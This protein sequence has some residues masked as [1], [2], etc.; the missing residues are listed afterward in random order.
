MISIAIWV[1]GYGVVGAIS[2]GVFSYVNRLSDDR[3]EIAIVTAAVFFLWPIAW[4]LGALAV[5][6]IGTVKLCERVGGMIGRRRYHYRI[7][8][9]KTKMMEE[10]LQRYN[11]NM[12]LAMRWDYKTCKRCYGSGCSSCSN[13][14]V[15]RVS[16]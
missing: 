2:G 16:A 14:G 8:K 13:E 11:G 4:G 6:A 7:I 1:F 12:E 5:I 15:E 10:D 3:D 9:A